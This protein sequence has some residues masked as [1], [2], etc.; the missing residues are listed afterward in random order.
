ML[1]RGECVGPLLTL[2]DGNQLPD[3]SQA[4]FYSDYILLRVTEL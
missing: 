3:L 2:P 1:A 4:S